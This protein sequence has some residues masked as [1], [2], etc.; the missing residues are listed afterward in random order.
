MKRSPGYTINTIIKRSIMTKM[1]L[2]TLAFY[3]K[4]FENT[5][6]QATQARTRIQ[7]QIAM[8]VGIFIYIFLGIID[9]WFVPPEYS[10][11]VWM[12]RF[13]ALTV[14]ITIL[15]LTLT[16]I[17]TRY[18]HQLLATVGLAAGIG[19]I[20]IQMMIPIQ[21]APYYYPLM[22][23]V[24]FYTY[25]FIGT[26][27]IYA[28]IVDISLLI[29]YNLVFGWMMDYPIHVLI[30]HDI[31]II[32]A[33]L[34]GGSVGY[35]TEWQ[36]RNLFVS[37][38][39]LEEERQHHMHRALHDPL[40]GLPNYDLLNDRIEQAM[41]L[42]ERKG[43]T[44]CG[45]FLDLDGFK[46]INDKLGHSTG[47]TVLQCIAQRLSS[48]FREM[49]TVSRVGGD[50]FFILALNIDNK[51]TASYMANKILEEISK[52]IPDIPKG[53]SLSASIGICLF[54]YKGM[55]V[56]DIIDRADEAMYK[57]KNSGKENFSFYI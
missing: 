54:P 9:Q 29:S 2:L 4:A 51:K 16:P 40:T 12:I 46:A 7:G 28:F 24:A 5:Y 57:V 39:K 49:D 32:S 43:N 37:E 53:I 25:N 21:S 22:V 6:I 15:L 34:I 20:G 36:R 13:T 44:H 1:N 8:L 30:S 27:F 50:E 11:K 23:L 47:D 18:A 41:I 35:L 38:R 56:S 33:N 55:T 14:P 45:F 31:Y 52:P 3:D 42:A 10:E 17:F 19:V 48:A 26:R